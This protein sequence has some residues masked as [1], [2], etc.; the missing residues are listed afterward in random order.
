VI[1]GQKKLTDEDLEP[2]DT[3][4]VFSPLDWC[5]AAG[6][7]CGGCLDPTGCS[8]AVSQGCLGCLHSCLARLGCS[9]LVMVGFL[10]LGVFLVTKLN[11]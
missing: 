3:R 6:C 1:D 10:A 11:S 9:V 5:L 2:G 7:G 8:N 4:E